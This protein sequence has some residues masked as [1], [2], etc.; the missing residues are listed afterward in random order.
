MP[1]IALDTTKGQYTNTDEF[2]SG[3][4][5]QIVNLMVDEHGTLTSR[6]GLLLFQDTVG[7]F[8]GLAGST[9]HSVAGLHPLGD[10][11]IA[12]T[13]GR[14]FK[15]ISS[16]G[17]VTDI[18]VDFLTGSATPSFLVDDDGSLLVFGGGVPIRIALSDLQSRSFGT[19]LEGSPTHGA[20]VDRILL[21]NDSGSDVVYFSDVGNAHN[22]FVRRPGIG[23]PGLFRAGTRKDPITAMAAL[24][25]RVLLFGDA[26]VEAFYGTGSST[27]PFRLEDDPMQSEIS[28]PRSLIEV[29][30]TLYWLDGDRRFVRL[31]GRSSA[32]V[33]TAVEAQIQAFTTHTDCV[34]HLVEL[35]GV[36]LVLLHFPAEKLTLCY[37]Y[38]RQVWTEWRLWSLTTG[39]WDEMPIR[40]YAFQPRWNRHF[41]AGYS[42]DLGRVFELSA[43]TY[44]DNATPL[45]RLWRGPYTDGGDLGLKFCK[46]LQFLVD[47]GTAQSYTS[48]SDGYNPTIEVRWRNEDRQWQ[49]WRQCQLGLI[50]SGASVRDVWCGSNYRRQQIE[51][52]SSSPVPLRVNRIELEAVPRMR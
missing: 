24:Q 42:R 6:P 25:N 33:S 44:Q 43:T 8:A 51:W 30:G 45:V 18:T 13:A 5:G 1:R 46:R 4:P 50:G 22:D 26:S 49:E 7:A 38:R 35:Q 17:A 32:P 31:E 20:I 27:G 14:R 52:R 2:A 12:V 9:D 47:G 37:D 39:D 11:M 28:A 36:H 29:D 34:T 41:C 40:A 16:T 3:Q 23:I 15:R 48:T 10:Y 21:V 19:G